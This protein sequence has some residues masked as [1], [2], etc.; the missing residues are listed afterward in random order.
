MTFCELLQPQEERNK[1]FTGKNDNTT[2]WGKLSSHEHNHE[3]KEI[4]EG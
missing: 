4:A 1:I 2:E 3:L